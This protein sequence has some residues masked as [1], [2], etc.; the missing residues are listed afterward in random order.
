[1]EGKIKAINSAADVMDFAK[2]C[3]RQNIWKNKYQRIQKIKNSFHLIWEWKSFKYLGTA[4]IE[5][6]IIYIDIAQ[7]KFLENKTGYGFKKNWT[8]R[9][10]N[11]TRNI[12]CI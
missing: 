10:W 12:F 9:T 8:H 6:H 11:V 2:T 7:R 1:V 3:I 4:L 5:D